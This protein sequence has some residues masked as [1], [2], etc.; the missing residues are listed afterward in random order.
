MMTW[1]YIKKLSK[2]DNNNFLL[3]FLINICYYQFSY[4]STQEFLT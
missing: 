4:Y 3:P 1:Q 2:S